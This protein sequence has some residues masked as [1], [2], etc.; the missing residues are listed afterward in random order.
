[1][2]EHWIYLQPCFNKIQNLLF[3]KK[4]KS[5]Q[6]Q[7]RIISLQKHY[8]TIQTEMSMLNKIWTLQRY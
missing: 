1:M 5:P 7:C 2:Q 3:K 6:K 4:K 8:H